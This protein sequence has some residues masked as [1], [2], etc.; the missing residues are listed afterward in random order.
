MLR[1]VSFSLLVFAAVGTAHGQTGEA[2]PPAPASDVVSPDPQLAGTWELA[3]GPVE[4]PRDD[5]DMTVDRLRLVIGAAGGDGAPVP[6]AFEVRT[7]QAVRVGGAQ[8]DLDATS[9]CTATGSGL[10]GCRPSHDGDSTGY[11]GLGLYELDGDVLT[12]SD[13]QSG[14]TTKL[15]RAEGGD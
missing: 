1:T 6:Q 5:V 8:R 13:P 15:R 14:M 9:W 2:A 3:D 4:F 10:I 12:L 11:G 7:T